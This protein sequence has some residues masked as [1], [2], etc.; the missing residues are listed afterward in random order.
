MS[1]Q[2][3]CPTRSYRHGDWF[4]IVG[5]NATVI[6][7]PSEKPRVAALWELLDDGA[8]FDEAL[9]ALIASG[10]RELPGFLLVSETDG[11]TKVVLRGEVRA[12]FTAAGETHELE[13]LS[14]TTWV[15][16][17]L[18]GVTQMVVL[19]AADD[20]QP[21]LTIDQGLVRI[22]RLDQP[23]HNPSPLSTDAM[24]MTE[25][26]ALP[27]AD[28]DATPEPDPV[29]APSE[30]PADQ[31]EVPADQPDPG[32]SVAALTFS[33]GEEL[34]VDTAVLV[35]RAPEPSRSTSDDPRLVVVHSPQLM[36][37]ATHLEI[38]P[39]TGP[40]EGTAVVTDL[41]STNGTILTQPGTPP[42]DL[43]PGIAVPLSPG[44]ALELGDGVTI[45]VSSA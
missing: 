36:V 2:I 29:I 3:N 45:E 25:A 10:L 21:D 17:S 23:A 9:D 40:D 34:E 37:S 18:R 32:R 20:S 13:G 19:L 24:T 1:E 42:L 8:G 31:P 26:F 15:E 22:S 5:A 12:S 41:G 38:R 16:R 27:E 28:S 30:V 33:S 44:A 7:P 14:A 6:L 39:G 4:G 11:E 35:G 43:Q